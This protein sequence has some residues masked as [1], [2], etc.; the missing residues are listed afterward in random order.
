VSDSGRE[1]QGMCPCC[2]HTLNGIGY[3]MWHCPRCGTL[4]GCYADGSVTIPAIV[5]RCR[6]FERGLFGI[7]VEELTVS[8]VRQEWKSYGIAESINLKEARPL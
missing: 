2:S 4:A 6:K 5:E 1:T 8:S 3:G 7:M